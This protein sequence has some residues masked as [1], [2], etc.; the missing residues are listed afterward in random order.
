[1]TD[2]AA[3]RAGF[4]SPYRV[5]DLTDHRGLLAGRI[6]AQ[7]GADVVQ[8]EPPSGSNGRRLGPFAPDG[9]SLHWAAYAAGKRSVALDPRNADDAETLRA[10]VA[11]ADFVLESRAPGEPARLS[12]EEIAEINPRAIHALITPFGEDGPK[13]DWAAT[14]LTLW[15]SGGPLLPTALVG[16]TPTRVSV[17]QAWNFAAAD[18]VSGALTAHFA[19]LADGRGQRVVTSVQRSATQATLSLT[20][21]DAVG[22]PDFSLRPRYTGKKKPV[23]MSGSGARTQRSKWR[24]REGLLEIHLAI[25]PATGRFTNAFMALMKERGALSERFADWDWSTLHHRIMNDEVSDADLEVLRAEVAA[26]LATMGK[27]EAVELAIERKLLLAP[28]A[29]VKD[30]VESPHETARGFFRNVADGQGRETLLPGPFALTDAPGFA[31]ERPAPEL[32]ADA[33]AVRADWLGAAPAAPAAEAAPA[34]PAR[35]LAG[36]KVLDLAWVVAGPMIG[37]NLADFGAEVVRVESAKRLETARNMGPYYGA[38]QD[39]QRS[40]LFANCNAGKLGLTLDLAQEAAREVVRD[41]ARRADVVLE[42]FAPGQMARWGLDYDSLRAENPSLIMLSTSLMGQSGPWRRMAG[43]GNIGAAMAGYQGLVGPR[44]GLPVGPY[45]PYTDYVG[46]RYGLTALL[47]A[48]DHRRRTGAGCWLD[49]S[50][51]E[52]GMQMLAPAIADYAASGRIAKAEGNRDPAM[53]PHGVFPCLT[54]EGADP[55]W[56]AIACRDDADWR[57]LAAEMGRPELAEAHPDLAARQAAEDA[58]EAAIAAWTEGLSP[59]AA[60]ERLQARGV[61]AHLAA[62]PTDLSHDPQIAAQGHFLALPDP[63]LGE[64]LVERCRFDLSRSPADPPRSAPGFGRD[65]DA[66]LQ[67][68]LGY[69]AARIAALEAADALS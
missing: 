56:V 53:A 66:V 25:G 6:F 3:G 15:A 61:P 5:L 16:G 30:L 43:F 64:Q 46:P 27:E 18:A 47:A 36:L 40:A 35:P 57:A 68:I 11:Q 22:H 2:P 12:P 4:L 48:L 28:V 14:D 23:D 42:S 33:A 21:A 34:D 59:E 69:D 52:A 62:S 49:V 44:E 67:G 51:A 63:V 26:F 1:M 24:A 55:R 58:L 10:L 13:A 32:D 17:P 54:P 60:Q 65:R 39:P 38:V 9:R 31:E 45:G 8:V 29:T 41:L 50:Q 19:R 37:R 20:L 7:L